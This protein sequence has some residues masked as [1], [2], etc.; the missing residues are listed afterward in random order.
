MDRRSP[1]KSEVDT[2]ARRGP[3]PP[4]EVARQVA[5]PGHPYH[6]NLRWPGTWSGS[7]DGFLRWPGVPTT[8]GRSR[9][10]AS[11]S[12]PGAGPAVRG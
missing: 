1:R 3:L 4:D 6:P 2:V 10:G 12:R 9:P 11:A 5:R 7:Y 8:G